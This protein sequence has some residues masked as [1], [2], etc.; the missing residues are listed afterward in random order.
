MKIHLTSS[1]IPLPVLECPVPNSFSSNPSIFLT[2]KL[3]LEEPWFH[4]FKWSSKLHLFCSNCIDT[5]AQWFE[6]LSI[7]SLFGSRSH[8]YMIH[9]IL[10]LFSLYFPSYHIGLLILSDWDNKYFWCKSKLTLELSTLFVYFS[11]SCS[12]CSSHNDVKME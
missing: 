8:L 6:C 10:H 2:Y 9:K 11:F 5:P 12:F 7:D 1:M 4:I 3:T